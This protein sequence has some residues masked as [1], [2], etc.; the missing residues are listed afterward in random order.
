MSHFI[1]ILKSEL[2]QI[3]EELKKLELYDTQC[4]RIT[5]TAISKVT[6]MSFPLVG[7]LSGKTRRIADK[8][9]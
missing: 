9:Q 6:L 2:R 3:K 4:K 7:N 8:P 1:A 5:K